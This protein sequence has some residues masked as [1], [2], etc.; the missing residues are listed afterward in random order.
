ME[1]LRDV[2]IEDIL[3]RE[4]ITLDNQNISE[5]IKDHVIM[6]TGWWRLYWFRAL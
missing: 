4:P 3:G 6:V 2:E 5:L 1:N